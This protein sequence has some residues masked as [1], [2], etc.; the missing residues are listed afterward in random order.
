MSSAPP[1]QLQPQDIARDAHW[2][3][4][5][6]DAPTRQARIVAMDREAYRAAS[7]LDDRLFARPMN[8]LIVPWSPVAESLAASNR[9]DARWIFHIGHVGSTLMARLLGEIPHVLALR[10]PR[11]LRDLAALPAEE[12][13]SMGDTVQRAFSR[14]FAADEVAL[15]KAT[16]AV[17][18]IAPELVPPGERAL[19]MYASPRA[20][21]ATILAGDAS[22]QE[23]RM[24]VDVR[25]ARSA[26]RISG[27][28][29]PPASDAHR[30]AAAWACEMTSIEAAADAMADR[31]IEWADFD[32][33][34]EDMEAA[35]GR[36]AQFFGFA[37]S[38]DQLRAIAHGPL[39]RRYSKALEY[40]Y[41]ANLRRDLIAEATEEHRRDI[42]DALAMLRAAAE[43][44]PLLARALQRAGEN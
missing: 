12:R 44:S 27:L 43:K 2:L 3:L 17:S 34:L 35:L 15:V 7:F 4:Q 6:Y 18:E 16:S 23:L 9:K 31:D 1:P 13:A 10:E 40:D 37:A 14:T 39:M 28:D 41:S 26:D 42:D 22:I 8:A 5:A 30:A 11:F 19:L 25:K 38:G 32:L 24:L 36:A 20:Y 29:R 21:I 33:M